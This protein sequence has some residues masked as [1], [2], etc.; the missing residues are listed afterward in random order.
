MAIRLQLFLR[1]RLGEMDSLLF[2]LIASRV[3]EGRGTG[4]PGVVAAEIFFV[5]DFL[6]VASDG[7]VDWLR[8]LPFLNR[9]NGCLLFGY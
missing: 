5:T 7:A 2:D 8:V 9:E 1:L 4:I 3:G 6:S